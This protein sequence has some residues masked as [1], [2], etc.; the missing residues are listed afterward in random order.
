MTVGPTILACCVPAGWSEI[1][2]VD[3]L[4]SESFRVLF[5]DDPDEVRFEHRCDRTKHYGG[6]PNRG[7][8]VA[9]PRLQVPDGHRVLQRRPLTIEG[10]I[11]CPDCG[12]H[13]FIRNSRWVPA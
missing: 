6:T 8:I 12:T 5:Y 11:L 13:G 7:V 10:S 9:A 2:M 1:V 4:A 3:S